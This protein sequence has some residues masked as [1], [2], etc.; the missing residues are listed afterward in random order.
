MPNGHQTGDLFYGGSWAAR[1][2]ASGHGYWGETMIDT[3]EATGALSHYR[4]VT[5][6]LGPLAAQAVPAG[7]WTIRI[8]GSENSPSANAFVRYMIYQWRSVTDDLGTVIVPAVTHGVELGTAKAMQAITAPGAA[9]ALAGGDK[10]CLDLLFEVNPPKPGG[11]TTFGCLFWG[12]TADSCSLS[13][14]VAITPL[15]AQLSEFSVRCQGS[16]VRI[17]WRTESENDCY[18]WHIE[19]GRNPEGPFD[20]LTSLPGRGNSGSPAE[21]S[22]TVPAPV[23]PEEAWYRLAE[24]ELNGTRA[25]YGPL[26]AAPCQQMSPMDWSARPAEGARGVV[27]DFGL[28]R[29][30]H[31]DIAVYNIAAQLEAVSELGYREPGRYQATVQTSGTSGLKIVRLKIN[32]IKDYRKIL[33]LR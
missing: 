9:C 28:T 15:S 12:S 20:W 2:L 19:R 1:T 26:R 4:A 27:V 29:T 10:I 11:P 21:Y 22:C 32:E 24:E 31:V 25:Y 13:G 17:A 16:D 30:S 5:A 8:F 33:L 3:F 18:R 23:L 7:N 6:V 14:P